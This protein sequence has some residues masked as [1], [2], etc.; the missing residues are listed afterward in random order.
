[1]ALGAEHGQASDTESIRTNIYTTTL[2]EVS[3]SSTYTPSPQV[4]VETQNSMQSPLLSTLLWLWVYTRT[5]GHFLS[6]VSPTVQI[7]TKEDLANSPV[8][9][10]LPCY[11]REVPAD[12]LTCKFSPRGYILVAVREKE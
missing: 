7:L 2:S 3:F 8:I 6:G 4:L 9:P 5:L 12:I 1:M 10:T 11:L